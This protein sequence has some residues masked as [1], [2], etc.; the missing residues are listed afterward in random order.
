[1]QGDYDDVEL[2]CRACFGPCGRCHEEPST[3]R[4]VITK[5]LESVKHG[6][7]PVVAPRIV[8]ARLG[9]NPGTPTTSTD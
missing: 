3:L 9:E 4:D 8:L 1:M 6:R 5:A 2:A 7:V